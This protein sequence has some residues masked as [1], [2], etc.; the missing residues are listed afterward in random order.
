MKPKLLMFDVDGTIV[1]SFQHAFLSAQEFIYGK[2]KEKITESDYRK[3]ILGNSWENIL[4]RIGLDPQ[5]K[6]DQASFSSLIASYDKLKLFDDIK[7]TLEKLSNAYP[8]IINTSTFIPTIMPVFEREKIDL[9]F[10]AYMGP[11][12]SIYK[13]TKIKIALEEFNVAPDELLFITDTVGD[14]M[15]A[16]KVG[17]KTVGVTWGFS[18]EDQLKEIGPDYLVYN[19]KELEELLLTQ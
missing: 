17:V 1:D 19:A 3:I 8:M 15:E 2:T 7:S 5:Q 12:V 10:S 11:E 4:I 16:K 18:T 13:D 14:I 9:F 6:V